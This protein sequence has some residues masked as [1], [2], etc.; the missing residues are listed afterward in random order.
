M[1]GNSLKAFLPASGALP[2]H[3]GLIS[4]SSPRVCVCVRQTKTQTK[5]SSKLFI[6]KLK[7]ILL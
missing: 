3:F 5:T 6:L 7:A 1:G 2:F 4:P